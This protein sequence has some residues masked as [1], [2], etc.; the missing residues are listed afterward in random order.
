MKATAAVKEQQ[1]S[2]PQLGLLRQ[3]ESTIRTRRAAKKEQA[4]LLA[5][6]RT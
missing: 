5:Q 2:R 1:K 4:L 6:V 3:H